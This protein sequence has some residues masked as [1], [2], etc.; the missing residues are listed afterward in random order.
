MQHPIVLPQFR[1]YNLFHS[2]SANVR[3]ERLHENGC[4]T[5]PEADHDSKG[6]GELLHS[7]E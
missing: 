7:D 3:V 6:D 1:Q 4:A 2:Q 5:Y